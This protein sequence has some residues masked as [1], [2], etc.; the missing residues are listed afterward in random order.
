MDE[1]G[2]LFLQPSIAIYISYHTHPADASITRVIT[3]FSSRLDIDCWAIIMVTVTKPSALFLRPSS[4]RDVPVSVSG[5]VSRGVRHVN[6]APFRMY[7]FLFVLMFVTLCYVQLN[8]AVVNIETETKRVTDNVPVEDAT[9]SRE[10]TVRTSAPTAST[11]TIAAPTTAPTTAPTA[12]EG[13]SSTTT[14]ASEVTTEVSP[15]NVITVAFVLTITSCRKHFSTETYHGADGAAVLGY[16]IHQNSI[17]GPKGGRYDY[18]LYVFH[19][20]DA[21]ECAA[22]L[23]ELGYIVEARDTPIAVDDIQNAKYREHLPTSGCCGE[24]ELIKFEAFTLVQY[25]I[26]VLM[27]VDTLLLKPLDRLF[28]FMLDTTKLP[29]PDDLM[30]VQQP[31]LV[32]I[33]SN[34]TIP[35]YLEFI[36][37]VD[38]S[39]VEADRNIKPAHGGF[40]IL[41]PNQSIYDDLKAIVIEGDYD[42]NGG[43][44]GGRT[45][46]FY[47]GTYEL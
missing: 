8:M 39:S 14:A 42:L 27:D 26:V 19:H 20:P 10:S 17:R 5:G 13:T 11:A 28:D 37:T 46:M 16:T 6:V 22:P 41:R 33:N 31:A 29:H 7:L 30:Y 4:S 21:A 44:W 18:Q 9:I 32:G 1:Q 15:P 25:P 43:G 35:K 38:Y 47:G 12:S 24:K 45:G 34:V 2:S 3:F 36:F 40:A 23:S